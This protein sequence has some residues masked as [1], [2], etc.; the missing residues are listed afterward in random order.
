MKKFLEIIK[1]KWLIKGTTTIALILIIIAIYLG[2]NWGVGKINMEDLDLTEK[3][4]YSISD[5]TKT[6]LKDLKDDIT[7]LLINQD[8]YVDNFVKKYSIYSDKIKVE[9]VLD[10]S[11]RADLMTKYN[12]E[13][14]DSLIVIQNGEKEKTLS[15]TDLVT[16]DYSA[17][18]QIDTT[19]EA[20]T[21]AIVGLTITEKPKIYIVSEGTYYDVEQVLTQ[22]TS[23]LEA[24]SNE[25]EYL[26][27]YTKG[28]IPEDC[29]CLVLTTMARDFSELERD[30]VLEYIN[31]GGRI[32][33]MT[34]Q[35]LLN[36]ET[37]NFNQILEQYGISIGYG[38]VIEQNSN[39]MLSGMPE[40]II[41]QASASFMSKIDMTLK[42]AML[43]AGKIEFADEDKLTELG[44]DYETISKSG[45]TSFVR[46]NF[47]LQTYSRTDSDS[48]EGSSITGALVTKKISDDVK[49]EL[50]IYSNELFATNSTVPVSNGYYMYASD[51]Y[52]NK[53]VILNSISYLTERQDTITI[54]KSNDEEKYTVTDAEDAII[55]TIIFIIPVLIIGIGIVVWQVRRR[56]K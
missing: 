4:L 11:S 51:L 9:E 3:K 28:G 8:N 33:M 46:N 14:T 53:D 45:D 27:I 37:P 30:K 40:F 31:R 38:A 7:I 54:R 25:I 29:D 15:S 47:S 19:E 26:D 5:E 39:Q 55:K 1:N 43:D 2:L 21:N 42:I 52:N 34:S 44:V 50:I 12:L 10:L 32:M 17:G 35:N 41:Q 24:D 13:S 56:K 49:S 18:K 20:V 36:I 16:Y 48:E 6:K 23:T 22:I